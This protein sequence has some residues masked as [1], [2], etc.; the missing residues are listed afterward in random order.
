ME[1]L[2]LFRLLQPIQP[3]LK[4]PELGLYHEDSSEYDW[5]LCGMPLNECTTSRFPVNR[6]AGF[7]LEV[8]YLM[9]ETDIPLRKIIYVFCTVHCLPEDE[10][11]GS[12]HVKDIKK[13]K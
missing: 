11:S 12:K 1:N 10:T 6:K 7:P 2:S 8:L 4:T 9:P 5:R 13:F 3:K